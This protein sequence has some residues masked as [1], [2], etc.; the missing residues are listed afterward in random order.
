M[1][2]AEQPWIHCNRFLLLNVISLPTCLLLFLSLAMVGWMEVVRWSF[3]DKLDIAAH[4]EPGQ[5]EI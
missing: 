5:D 1:D 2:A 3:S 4:D